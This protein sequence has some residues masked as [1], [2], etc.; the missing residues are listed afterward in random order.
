MQ[1][2]A[3][4][5]EP[6]T[7]PADDLDT[8]A[9]TRPRVQVV[10]LCLCAGATGAVVAA[11]RLPWFGS[12]ADLAAPEKSADSGD[13]WRTGLVPGAQ[14]WGY[15]LIAWSGLL[16]VTALFAALACVL[17]PPGPRRQLNRLLLGLG[18]ASSILIALV[19][20]ELTTSAQYDL[21]SY[22]HS[23]WGAWA[24]LGLAVASS[25]G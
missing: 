25:V 8:D 1:P 17:F 19:V 4:E 16:A 9:R 10:S 11:V 12:P 13:L 20:A 7:A 2:R 5:A 24:G 6:L 18:V 23:D 3:V 15:L 22:A 21:V 14:S